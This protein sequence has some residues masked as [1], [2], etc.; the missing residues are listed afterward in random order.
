MKIIRSVSFLLLLVTSSTVFAEPTEKAWL[1]SSVDQ[2]QRQLV[3]LPAEERIA[4][5]LEQSPR[6]SESNLAQFQY[7]QLVADSYDFNDDLDQ[8]GVI[9][10]ELESE[11]THIEQLET[12]VDYLI[13]LGFL[14]Y[15]ESLGGCDSYQQAYELSRSSSIADIR[16]RA[17]S[18]HAYCL[19][20][21]LSTLIEAVSVLTDAL[22]EANEN[23]LVNRRKALLLSSLS[24]TYSRLL[25]YDE[26][27][28]ANDESIRLFAEDDATADV[29]SGVYTGIT[30]ALHFSYFADAADYLDELNELRTQN[31]S[32]SEVSF[33]YYQLLGEF[34]MRQQ[35]PD[36]VGAVN[37][38]DMAREFEESVPERYLVAL[39]LTNLL[40][41]LIGAGEMERARNWLAE[42]RVHS[43]FSEEELFAGRGPQLA[44][45]I[46]ERDM[47]QAWRLTNKIVT[48]QHRAYYERFRVLRS[49]EALDNQNLADRYLI[50]LHEQEV[51]LERIRADAEAAKNLVASRN[52]QLLVIALL[53]IAMILVYAAISRRTFKRLAHTDGLSRLMNRRAI[54]QV[55]ENS[56]SKRLPIALA[57]IDIDHFKRVNDSYGHSVGD[58]VIREVATLLKA[59]LKS[60]DRIGRYGGEE[61]LL[62]TSFNEGDDVQLFADELRRKIMEADFAGVEEG[63]TI[64]IGGAILDFNHSAD[65]SIIKADEA[66]Y[67]AKKNGRNQSVWSSH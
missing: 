46:V 22:D 11:F 8:Y 52:Q 41:A 44:K 60:T 18:K 53:F 26:G 64:S 4:W 5:L 65:E 13:Q 12:K 51:E 59:S 16:V 45:F 42:L 29:V 58:Q 19:I 35:D 66:L 24:Q 31:D 48:D 30:S 3:T 49:S 54:L 56:Y 50:N 62:V 57:L 2:I 67:R 37:A 38:L 21:R 39:N 63:V 33:Y 55:V 25:M 9:I 34:L 43:E 32:S 14:E 7:R 17:A 40:S 27:K 10:R 1:E 36:Y 47:A 61:F 15:L 23:A 20:L 28:R 6:V